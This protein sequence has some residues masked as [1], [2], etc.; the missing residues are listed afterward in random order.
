ME[1][2][3][4]EEIHTVF[5]I[6][7]VDLS[8]YYPYNVGDLKHL[9][10]LYHK[11]GT[12]WLRVYIYYDLHPNESKNGGKMNE[13]EVLT[14]NVETIPTGKEE[15]TP[16]GK[17]EMTSPVK[18]EKK[19]RFS[20]RE[21]TI[22]GML[23]AVTILLGV[24]GYGFIPLPFMKATILHVPTIIGALL[25]GPRVG[26]IV[27]FLFGC[28]SMMQNILAPNI[29]SFAFLN[30]M[31]SILPRVL[32]GP[33]A[34][35]VYRMLPIRDNIRIA[36]SSFVGSILHTVLVLGMIFV[37]YAEHYA[38]VRNIDPQ[39]VINILLGVAVANGIPEA[40]VCAVITTPVVIM[41]KKA[42]KKKA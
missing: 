16:T 28:F 24:T 35:M 27:G 20:V 9:C 1:I 25:A 18:P 32:V 3:K 2:V 33:L 8:G 21:L 13:K 23:G 42:I 11:N 38:Q 6:F 41:V 36:V 17:P 26:L 15:M 22:I 14:S 19:G 29:M 39:S 12:G 7:K 30:P 31:V 37:L 40:V 5:A 10:G 34:Y 4:F